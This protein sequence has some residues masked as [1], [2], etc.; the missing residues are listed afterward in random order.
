MLSVNGC[1]VNS[2]HVSADRSYHG[3]HWPACS[4]SP[5]REQCVG[6]LRLEF[7]RSYFCSQGS[8]V[9][10]EA[11]FVC[12]WNLALVSLADAVGAGVGTRVGSGVGA[13]VGASVGCMLGASVW[14]MQ[15]T[16]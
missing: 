12:V 4:I 10:R 14:H 3:V 7:Q 9:H 8:S 15:S 16:Q 2:A 11:W 13:R 5:G 6:D 1:I